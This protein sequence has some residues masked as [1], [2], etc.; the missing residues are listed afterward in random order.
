MYVKKIWKYTSILFLL[1]GM[2]KIV[3]IIEMLKKEN[4]ATL[5]G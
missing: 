4:N 5:K 3:N 2:L 1:E